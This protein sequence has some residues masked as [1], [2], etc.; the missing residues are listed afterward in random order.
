MA[1]ME[2]VARSSRSIP[3]TGPLEQ[4]SEEIVPAGIGPRQWLILPMERVMM[5]DATGGGL[6]STSTED[7]D[8]L[9]ILAKKAFEA[10]EELPALDGQQPP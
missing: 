2:R 5:V 8:V 10:D 4:S 7:T 1:W 3:L 6:R 9:A